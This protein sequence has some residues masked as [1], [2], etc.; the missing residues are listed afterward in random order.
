MRNVRDRLKRL[1]DSR[2][3]SVTA[4]FGTE[5]MLANH[6]MSMMSKIPATPITPGA[7]T[8]AHITDRFLAQRSGALTSGREMR[9]ILERDLLPR[10]GDRPIASIRRAEIISLI[11]GKAA[12]APRAAALLLGYIKQVWAYALDREL[13]DQD[14]TAGLRPRRIHPGLRSRARARVLSD[15]EIRHFW[16][17][18]DRTGM[19][20]LTAIALKLILVTGQ[21]PGEVAGMRW[22]EI[23]EQ[24]WNIPPERRRKTAMTHR[25]YLSATARNLLQAAQ[26]EAE[27]LARRRDWPASDHVFRARQTGAITVGAL[28]RAVTRY[29]PILFIHGAAWTPH[30]LRRTCRTGLAAS[31]IGDEVAERV[32]GHAPRGIV[33][34]YN[35]HRYAAEMAAALDAWD[36]KLRRIVAGEH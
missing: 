11:E 13:I 29:G 1:C 34:T 6:A 26:F 12:S 28:G 31:G 22:R 8:V 14:C 17:S 9:R 25:V 7:T 30:D 19:H 2:F 36:A 27:R 33:A 35:L 32:I 23:E 18:L 4:A 20:R 15:A 10:L 3:Q 21:R 24:T 16:H 5:R